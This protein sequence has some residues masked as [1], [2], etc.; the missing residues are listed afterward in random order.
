MNPLKEAI[1]LMTKEEVRAFKLFVKKV[2]VR[3]GRKDLDLFD[4]VRKSGTEYDEKAAFEH[5]Y[6]GASKN[7]FHRLK[8]RLL[9]DINRS[10]VDLHLSNN[11]ILR[12]WNF[13][14][15]VEFYLL[16]SHFELSYWFLRKAENLASKLGHLEALDIVYG[17]YIRLS[18]E[19]PE[20]YPADFIEKRS[21]NAKQLQ[22]VRALDDLLA[23]AVYRTKISQ[24]WGSGDS[25]LMK[26]LEKTVAEFT[27]PELLTSGTRIKLFQSVISILLGRQDYMMIEVYVRE[28]YER[29]KADKIF[30]RNTHET[31]LLMLTYLANALHK[32]GKFEE[33]LKYAELLGR[34][35]KEYDSALQ[36]RYLFFYYN[37]LMINYFRLEIGKAVALLNEMKQIPK[38]M[39]APFHA[40][41]VEMNLGLAYNQMGSYRKAIKSI[42]Q[43]QLHEA[44]KSAAEGL[45]LR[46]SVAELMIRLKLE[47]FE[48]LEQRFR[49]V[50]GD[51]Q[52]ALSKQDFVRESQLLSIL[53]NLNEN[54]HDRQNK[55][56]ISAIQ[57]FLN[58]KVAEQER[59]AELIDY[60][61][62][63]KEYLPA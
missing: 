55:K 61:A 37:V 13:L 5:V 56:T 18:H 50:K 19:I 51:F 7:T 32:N 1:A 42:V 8:S 54:S 60:D 44:Y 31:K 26:V 41:F 36:D 58:M 63:L 49:Q 35:M 24:T 40:L 39:D 12:L 10:M 23:M 9:H 4:F 52:S 45:R 28:N 20:I 47:Q 53:E 27:E 3:A 29:F 34:E 14:S 25:D 59:D 11:D 38:I 46:I 6:P 43:A 16:R 17:I 2:N 30:N 62:Y 15:V 57:E 48:V 21:N 22:K 33:S